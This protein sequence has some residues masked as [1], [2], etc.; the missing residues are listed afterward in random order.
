MSL[1]DPT[2]GRI[3]TRQ[4]AADSAAATAGIQPG[5]VISEFNG[6]AVTDAFVL[7]I[8]L[9]RFEDSAFRSSLTRG[10]QRLSTT[11]NVPPDQ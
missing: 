1:V 4:V 8:E 6:R 11:L 5:D 10:D 3:T 9:Q 7:G 2:I